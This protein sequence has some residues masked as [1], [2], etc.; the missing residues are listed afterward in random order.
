M[1]RVYPVEGG[2]RWCIIG[3]D[4]RPLYYADE[5]VYP[6]NHAAAAAAV[7]WRTNFWTVACT[8]DSRQPGCF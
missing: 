2:F 3:I 4:G 1:F 8:I 7:Q 6:D 5:T